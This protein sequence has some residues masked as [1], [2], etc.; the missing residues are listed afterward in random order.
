MEKHNFLNLFRIKLS[1]LNKNK[2]IM[3]LNFQQITYINN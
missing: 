1:Q 2:L 3:K